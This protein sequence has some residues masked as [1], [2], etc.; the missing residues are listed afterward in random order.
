MVDTENSSTRVMEWL[1]N[2]SNGCWF[3]LV[4]NLTLSDETKDILGALPSSRKITGYGQILITTRDLAAVETLKV[5]H[6][7]ACIQVG[8]LSPRAS[9]QLFSHYSGRCRY[10]EGIKDIGGDKFQLCLQKLWSPGLI[11][12]VASYM[13][14]HHISISQMFQ[15]CERE[16]FSQIMKVCP[17]Y[18][19]SLLEPLLKQELSPNVP[20]PNEVRLLFI[21]AFFDSSGVDSDILI[22]HYGNETTKLY[23]L[24]GRL[25]SCSLIVR[26]DK[27]CG[28]VY[29]I[30]GNIRQAL[31]QWVKESETETDPNKGSELLS[32][33]NRVLS[34]MDH[35][36]R[37]G[38]GIP[39]DIF[40]SRDRI[41]GRLD[42]L[43]PHFDHFIA[44][45]KEQKT[46]INA[47]MTK[48]AV[49]AVI[50][51][52]FLLLDM[53]ERHADAIE[54]LDFTFRHFN[55][56]SNE[57]SSWAV[58]DQKNFQK[59]LQ[60]GRLL[61]KA[62]L[63]R[64]DQGGPNRYVTRAYELIQ[65]LKDEATKIHHPSREWGEQNEIHWEL[66]LDLIRVFWKA[67]EFSKAHKELA[68]I[69][70]AVG[71][72]KLDGKNNVVV[73]AEH[74]TRTSK[75][76]H[77]LDSDSVE[78]RG[79]KLRPFHRLLARMTYEGGLI[80]VAEAQHCVA[81]DSNRGAA[82]H[83]R[84][85]KQ[86]LDLA[87]CAVRQWSLLETDWLSDM[88][89]TMAIVNVN[90]GTRQGVSSAISVFRQ[91][92][93]E[94]EQRYGQIRRTWTT[95]RKLNEALLRGDTGEVREAVRSS[96]NVLVVYEE[97]YG[98][99]KPQTRS[100]ARQ[101][102]FGLRR[103]RRREEME[104]LCNKYPEL[105][106][107]SHEQ[108]GLMG[109]GWKLKLI[110]AVLLAAVLTFLSFQKRS[111]MCTAT[112]IGIKTILDK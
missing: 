47:N 91:R 73:E 101:L 63:S 62:Y 96:Q 23:Q 53:D 37:A 49:S 16:G 17:G 112:S 26:M 97:R 8:S 78:V 66:K 32:R 104:D 31:I 45:T 106:T 33:H 88:T 12:E 19:S 41:H 43:L 68:T 102:Y 60:L 81:E 51:F 95:T 28:A 100:C 77:T 13:S 75:W 79:R 82:S 92:V 52:S 105:R 24:L 10:E 83:W 93:V 85:A 64:P 58:D 70:D 7:K 86:A 30:N 5:S 69:K 36:F 65:E 22:S 87:I 29:I 34:I 48:A 76:L 39:N 3:L 72:L 90:I 35:Y 46:R 6:T 71:K 110:A 20:L 54:V 15:I 67:K 59:R 98:C 27:E 56:S 40:D 38:E 25:I 111:D 94:V 74:N 4:E 11:K 99:D 50:N 61:F 80:E 55:I 2:P 108:G 103:L 14:N 42:P 9:Q 1:E 21:L 107:L 84:A 57:K 89:E 44:F 18:L 109:I